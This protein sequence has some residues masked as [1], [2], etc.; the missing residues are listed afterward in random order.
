M[1]NINI[2]H[3]ISNSDSKFL[4]SLPGFAIRIIAKII[5][6]TEINQLMDT[7]SEYEGV[8]LLPKLIEE[9]NIKIEIEGKE[10]LSDNGRCV[11]VANHP[12]GLLDGLIL[13]Y[14]V[15]EKYGNLKAIGNE[16]FMFIPNLRPIIADVSVFAKNS[17]K[18]IIELEEVY[19][20]DVPITHFPFGLVSRV[21]K[22]K[23]QDKHW[24]K[25]FVK[26][27]ISNQ[28]DVV[29]IR[30]Y[31]RN[32]TLFY[33]IYIFRQIFRIKTNLELILLPRELFRKKGKTVR[34]KIAKPI[35]YQEFNNSLSH[36][37]WAQKVRSSVYNSDSN[38]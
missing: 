18:H 10:N 20:S 13:T 35:H 3:I 21:Y 25:S 9:F 36:W 4:K 12:F 34:V 28:R 14:I 29:P 15:G 23:I 38:L 27:A 7:Y 2:A 5:K 33:A 22:F 37:E 32:S 1:K 8:D 30:F 11:F 19:N 16:A 6:Q 31:G 24:N 17:R 26:K